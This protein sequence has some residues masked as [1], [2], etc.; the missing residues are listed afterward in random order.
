MIL[1]H[2]TQQAVFTAFCPQPH[3]SSSFKSPNPKL[4]ELLTEGTKPEQADL[5]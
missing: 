2:L 3:F 5:L 1:Q 4:Y